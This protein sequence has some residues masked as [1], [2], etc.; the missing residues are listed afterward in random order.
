MSLMRLLFDGAAHAA[1]LL[2]LA[3]VLQ[4]GTAAA[5][6]PR[7]SQAVVAPVAAESLVVPAPLSLQATHLDLRIGPHAVEV[8]TRLTYRNAGA[9]VIEAPIVLPPDARLVPPG[10]ADDEEGIADAPGCGDM[11]ADDAQ[12][13]EAGEA[14]LVA[15]H[16]APGEEITIETRRAASASERNGRYRLVLPLPNDSSAAF[17]PR[18]SAQVEVT[19]PQPVRQLL[20][21]THSGTTVGIGSTTATLTIPDGRVY[22]GRYLAVEYEFDTLPSTGSVMP[23]QAAWGGEARAWR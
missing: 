13:L 17:V 21:P 23:S 2:P 7:S 9:D 11:V 10:L 8:R 1:Q 3:F 19:T 20:S 16:V 6:L 12:F 14:P 15:L 5:Q 18:F 4:P 22:G